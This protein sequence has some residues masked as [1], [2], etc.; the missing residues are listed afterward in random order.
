MSQIS[1]RCGKCGNEGADFK[2]HDGT[3]R[4]AIPGLFL[5]CKRCGYSW[6]VKALDEEAQNTPQTKA[7][8]P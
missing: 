2:W 3:G 6:R 1:E 7:K 5:I 8:A 4:I